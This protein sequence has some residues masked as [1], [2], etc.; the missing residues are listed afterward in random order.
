MQAGGIGFSQLLVA[1]F[2]K[3]KTSITGNIA[4]SEFSRELLKQGRHL[5]GATAGSDSKDGSDAALV[6]AASVAGASSVIPGSSAKSNSSTSAASENTRTSGASGRYAFTNV[7]LLEKVLANGRCSAEGR[8]A[9]K[10]IDDG[11]SGV[12]LED[13][14]NVLKKEGG[15]R[16]GA[17]KISSSDLTQLVSSLKQTENAD[18][19]SMDPKVI[20]RC[21]ALVQ[22]R[23]SYTL[24]QF[25]DLLENVSSEVAEAVASSKVGTSGSTAT[26]NPVK[27]VVASARERIL[28]GGANAET[29]NKDIQVSQWMN[30]DLPAFVR[31]AASGVTGDTAPANAAAER[32]GGPSRKDD[33]S[34]DA[35]ASKDAT[36]RANESEASNELESMAGNT[37]SKQGVAVFREE[38]DEIADAVAA[39]P[40]EAGLETNRNRG[41]ADASVD[42]RETTAQTLDANN[43][44]E[45]ASGVG[46]PYATGV[47]AHREPVAAAVQGSVLAGSSREVRGEAEKSRSMVSGVEGVTSGAS[48]EGTLP[49]GEVAKAS[50]GEI[51][52]EAESAKSLWPEAETGTMR[53]ARSD[54]DVAV[55]TTKSAMDDLLKSYGAENAVFEQATV[56]SV[57]TA[58]A[59]EFMFAQTVVTQSVAS[60]SIFEAPELEAV[61]SSEPAESK[62]GTR[63]ESAEVIEDYA[64]VFSKVRSPESGQVEALTTADEAEPAEQIMS[65]GKT[66]PETVGPRVSEAVQVAPEAASAKSQAAIGPEGDAVQAAMP[67]L[68]VSNVEYRVTAETV[69]AEPKAVATNETPGSTVHETKHTVPAEK[70]TA[71]SM[72]TTSDALRFSLTDVNVSEDTDGSV[73]NPVNSARVQ[74]S[75]ERAA[76]VETPVSSKVSNATTRTAANGYDVSGNGMDAVSRGTNATV[77]AV[78]KPASDGMRVEYSRSEDAQGLQIG[79]ASEPSLGRLS[80]AFLRTANDQGSEAPLASETAGENVTA[81]ATYTTGSTEQGTPEASECAVQNA[82]GSTR[83]ENSS[84]KGTS[85]VEDQPVTMKKASDRGKD[86]AGDRGNDGGFNPGNSKGMADH[87]SARIATETSARPAFASVE[88]VVDQLQGLADQRKELSELI[89][90]VPDQ[91]SGSLILKVN[92]KNEEVHAWVLTN[93]QQTRDLLMR[94]VPLLRQHLEA[95]GL[96]LTGLSVDVRQNN[97]GDRW[98]GLRYS[99]SK[100]RT[101]RT[102]STSGLRAS[103]A[104]QSTSRAI[105]GENQTINLFA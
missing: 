72:E 2:D 100:S 26:T 67:D 75:T 65:G 17:G 105:M 84:E 34:G 60:P 61:P 56:K 51:G 7:P 42:R 23:A 40:L 57:S 36:V 102:A 53:I 46:T 30:S 86:S 49:V 9:C 45:R 104:S 63:T 71:G 93:N 74:M 96:G 31:E 52:G 37:A 8:K 81:A 94:D 64:P 95:Q 33:T 18:S 21:V 29:G 12:S 28:A 83:T 90:E 25:R 85:S 76:Q 82:A 70:L 20:E 88:E 89:L 62:M 69:E 14:S 54:G 43:T 13:L 32:V 59:P 58:N 79:N 1:V 19:G 5:E 103:Y 98:G 44:A 11:V 3:E 99:D 24:P 68:M 15:R 47:D 4:D 97:S 78:R 73:A 35:D 38:V 55:S 27:K 77:E 80:N 22:Q 39:N 87:K 66:A 91:D 10:S 41:T 50:G 101:S 48:V 6:Q 16:L 92:T